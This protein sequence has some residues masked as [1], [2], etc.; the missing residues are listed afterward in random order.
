M[1]RGAEGEPGVDSLPNWRTGILLIFFFII[2]ALWELGTRSLDAYLRRRNKRGLRHVVDH[3]KREILVL[4]VIS[5]LIIPFEPPLTSLCISCGEGYSQQCYWECGDSSEE[6]A[7]LA[8]LHSCGAGSEPLW[9]TLALHQAHI[10]LF[11]I[12]VTHIV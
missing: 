3:L 8:E 1:A 11:T 6:P 9:S 10:M 5:L 7:C 12:A 4:G 2:A